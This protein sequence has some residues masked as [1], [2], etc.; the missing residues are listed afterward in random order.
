MATR[1]DWYARSILQQK[2]REQVKMNGRCAAFCL[3][4]TLDSVVYP[5]RLVGKFLFCKMIYFILF[6]GPLIRRAAD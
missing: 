5:Q 6:A 1:G 2:E 4:M 3:C